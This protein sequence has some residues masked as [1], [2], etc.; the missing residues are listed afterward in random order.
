VYD[1][2]LAGP[3]EYAKI[4]E[5]FS[6]D[7]AVDVRRTA[8]LLQAEIACLGRSVETREPLPPD[9]YRTLL[10]LSDALQRALGDEV[11]HAG[12]GD[13]DAWQRG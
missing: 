11:L 1:K 9:K 8:A 4:S 12:R 7:A 6:R 5:A 10:S 2:P 13:P 3:I